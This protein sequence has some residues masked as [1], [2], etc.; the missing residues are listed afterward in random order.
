VALIVL[1][2]NKSHSGTVFGRNSAT[3]GGA[4]YKDDVINTV[5]LEIGR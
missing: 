1:V 4:I 3:W 2:A 5:P